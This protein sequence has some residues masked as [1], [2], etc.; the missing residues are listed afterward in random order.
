[1]F[2]LLSVRNRQYR[3]NPCTKGYSSDS[4]YTAWITDPV[5]MHAMRVG[6]RLLRPRDISLNITY[7]T[8][9]RIALR[10]FLEYVYYTLCECEREYRYKSHALMQA[11]PLLHATPTVEDDVLNGNQASQ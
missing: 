10:R 1:M 9:Y 11:H 7:R 5:S 6:Q 2:H 4:S 3:P 8:C